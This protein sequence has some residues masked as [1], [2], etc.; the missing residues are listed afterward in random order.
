MQSSSSGSQAIISKSS[1][2]VTCESLSL[3][4]IN[5]TGGATYTANNS[6]DL[7]N[8]SGWTINTATSLDFYW[9][10]GTGNW[11]DPAH[12]AASSGGTGGYCLPTAIDDVFF[13]ANSFSATGQTVTINI[14]NAVCRIMDWSG[15][16][17]NP[18]INGSYANKLRIYGSLTFIENMT[19]SFAG[20][21]YFEATSTGHAIT[22]AG[23]S[24][25]NDITFQG[26]NGSWTLNDSLTVNSNIYFVHGNLNTNNNNFSC[27]SFYSEYSGN[28]RSINISNSTIRCSYYWRVIGSN[29]SLVIPNSL[30]ICKR[31]KHYGD[32]KTYNDLQLSND[33]YLECEGGNSIFNKITFLDNI[34]YATNAIIT[35]NN[36]IDSLIFYTNNCII[37]HADTINALLAYNNASLNYEGS[38]SSG[39]IIKYAKFFG[40]ANIYNTNSFDTLIFSPGKLYNLEQ[41]KT[42]TVSDSLSVRGNNCYPIIIRSSSNGT[43]ATITKP[44]GV[45]SG[46][47]LELRDM[48]A[49]GG[50]TYYAGSYSTNVSNNSGWIFTN[51]PGY[52]Y[53][54]GPDTSVCIGD[55][56]VTYNFNGAYAYLWQNGDTLPYFT[57]TEPGIYWVQATYATNCYY[58]DTVVVD[59][60]PT[61][62]SLSGSD[63]AICF[64]DTT[65]LNG[66]ASLGIPPYTYQWTPVTGLN[67]PTSPTPLAYPTQTTPY[68]LRTMG[69]NGCDGYDTLT[70]TVNPEIQ[71]SF[72]TTDPTTCGGNDGTA[73][74]NPTGGTPQATPPYYSFV[75]N[76]TPVQ[77]TQTASGLTAGNYLVTVS[78][79]ENCSAIFSV[80]LSDP[81]APVVSLQVSDTSIC[82]GETVT[83]TASGATLYEFFL[84][85]ISLGIPALTNTLD[86]TFPDAGTVVVSFEGTTTGCTSSSTG[87]TIQITP[88]SP[89]SVS[90]SSTANPVAQGTEVTFTALPVNGGVSPGYQWLVNGISAG[91]NIATYTYT[92]SNDDSVQCI[93]TSNIACPVNNPDTSNI[94]VMQVES[95]TS[96]PGTPT[97]TYAS[98]TYN[99]VQIGTQCWLKENLDV[100][101][102][103]NTTDD[104]TD[105]S[106]IEKYCYDN[107]ST[108]CDIYGGMYQW[109]ELMAYTITPR[110]Q[111]ICPPGWVI[112][113]RGDFDVLMGYLGGNSVAGGPLKET[114]LVHW[115]SP[116]T[117]ATNASGFTALPGGKYYINV[118]FLLTEQ[119][120]LASSTIY[121]I[122]AQQSWAPEIRHNAIHIEFNNEP[123]ESGKSVRCLRDTCGPV[124]TST[125]GQD[126]ISLIGTTATLAANTPPAWQSGTWTIISGAGGIV[127]TPASPTSSFTG[128]EGTSYELV[129]T[130]SNSCNET[131]HDTVTISFNLPC[132]GIPTVLYEGKTYNTVQIGTQCWLKENLDVG[133]VTP[134]NQNQSNDEII[135]KYCYDNLTS[136]CDIYGGIYQWGE[137]MQYTTEEETQGICPNGWHIPSDSELC[138]LEAYLDPLVT[139][140]TTGW[141]GLDGGGKMKDVDT[142]RWQSPNIG[143]TNYSGF[144]ALPGGYR[145]VYGGPI[146]YDLHLYITL[147]SSTQYNGT[148]A[149][150]HEINYN[151][152]DILRMDN[153]KNSGYSVRCVKDACSSYDTVCVTISTSNNTVCAGDSVTFTATPVN[154]GSNPVYQWKINGI[155]TGS[156]SSLFQ[157]IPI[158]NDTV[159]CILT[160]SDT[161]VTNNPDTSNLVVMTVTP[162]L[163]VSI[164]ITASNDTICSGESVTFTATATNEGTTPAFQWKVNGIDQGTNSVSFDYIPADGDEVSCIL[165][166]NI[167]CPSGNPATSN[168]ITIKVNPKPNTN[169]IWHQ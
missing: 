72:N 51:S 59:T 73:T 14:D 155:D 141:S 120:V 5:A 40:N 129:W 82:A 114:G 79:A 118:F 42:Q 144:T 56:L 115:A 69:A 89:V 65:Q 122:S 93:M 161:C 21:V 136:N 85:G 124:T 67:N 28:L 147:W 150:N 75:W 8:N 168:Q 16:E 80:S 17:Y 4:D 47:F 52:I 3:R 41:N 45:V 131:S 112:P 160:S 24:F 139:C 78:D 99:T 50:A 145:C 113:T 9:V 92:P 33:N 102:M 10:G 58:S 151:R 84:N 135:E 25:N 133:I 110:S 53:G 70:V 116:N 152:A 29:L 23:K 126:Q 57:V 88:I 169:G 26:I 30:I 7:G 148:R 19:F 159:T 44:G 6:V 11:D 12:W 137:L 163:P 39:H 125:A 36:T 108:N 76:T 81:T 103:I 166:S 66:T 60:L 20:L 13:D 154:S 140:Q 95:W 35:E 46:D 2:A 100:G 18:T 146:F 121:N 22:S 87:K 94:I 134:G 106:I 153:L 62:V 71:A 1:G 98:K 165:T 117:G 132:T 90:I 27:E 77:T 158:G 49:T 127:V 91:S 86:I 96:C 156:N 104:Q 54:L 55:T 37:Y 107:I 162:L 31:F 74:I 105:N 128:T 138:Q 64:G 119:A 83:L 149:Y 68:V 164:T 48:N 167:A 123:W 111:G 32:P 142:I 34:N 101:T 63:A 109:N 143:A 157:Y 38:S 15:A 97:V 61:P 43:Q 130:I